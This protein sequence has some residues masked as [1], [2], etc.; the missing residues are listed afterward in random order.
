MSTAPQRVIP[1]NIP[2]DSELVDDIRAVVP[3][4]KLYRPSPDWWG[5]PFDGIEYDM[6]PD[7]PGHPEVPHPT[8]S[9][10]GRPVMVKADGTLEVHDRYGPLLDPKTKK[11]AGF[12]PVPGHTAMAVAKHALRKH[13]QHGV[14]LLR[15]DASDA[16]RKK[17]AQAMFLQHQRLWAEAQVSA[18]AKYV[19]NFRKNKKN[20]GLDPRDPSPLQALA[21]EILDDLLDSGTKTFRYACNSRCYATNDLS[22]FERHLRLRHSEEFRLWQ[23][24]SNEETAGATRGKDGA[25][26]L[27]GAIGKPGGKKKTAAKKT[28]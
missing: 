18:R 2:T 26:K 22:K 7:L 27:A 16:T 19:E 24:D 5:F 28:A 11:P 14:T 1:D 23:M 8:R 10:N 12:G 13:Q 3:G 4:L 17:K 6:P 25:E 15:G 9:D 20:Q 21:Q